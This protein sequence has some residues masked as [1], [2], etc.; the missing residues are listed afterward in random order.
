[1]VERP[2]IFLATP[3]FGGQVK[4]G[5]MQS[6][7]G[8]MH[9]ANQEGFDMSIGLL[10]QDALITRCRNTLLGAFMEGGASHLL[11]IDSDIEFA[12]AAVVR[13]LRSGKDVVA[14]MYPIKDLNW[15]IAPHNRQKFGE[16]GQAACLMYVGKP[17]NPAQRGTPDGLI[18]A[19]YAGTGFMMISRH[20][21]ER[22]IAAYP[23][24]RYRTIHAWPL[25][26]GPER[27]RYA[28]FDTMIVPETGEY[29]SEDYAFCHRWHAIGGDIWLDTQCRLTHIGNAEYRGN[30]ITRFPV[31]LS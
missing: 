29:L 4:T 9:V 13:L 12:P 18:P 15:E 16:E 3:C 7:L 20:A 27:E 1:M 25:P 28:L 31:G 17:E 8:L 21:G 11:F 5:Y 6:V 14:G 19:T 22:L 23:E 10:G 26:K 30:P 24:T 2:H